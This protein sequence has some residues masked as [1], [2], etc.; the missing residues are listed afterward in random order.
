M[1]IPLIICGAIGSAPLISGTAIAQQTVIQVIDLSEKGMST[2]GGEAT[3]YRV[4]NTRPTICKIDVI[5]YSETGR[6]ILE[7]EFGVKLNAAEAREYR[8]KVP[9][10]EDPHAKPKLIK[11]VTMATRE[12]RETLQKEFEAYK[13]FFAASDLE[14][15][16]E[17]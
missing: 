16:L 12:G 6:S 17:G 14:K 3:L 2:E 8:Y 10:A 1:R 4:R 13:S 9:L 5:H 15:C 7:F 11:T